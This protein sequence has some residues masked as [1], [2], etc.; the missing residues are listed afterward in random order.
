MHA[1]RWYALIL[2]LVD[3]SGTS[4]G[5][6][7]SCVFNDISVALSVMPVSVHLNQMHTLLGKHSCCTQEWHDH[8]VVVSEPSCHVIHL[9]LQ[10]FL[11]PLMVFSGFFVN[12]YRAQH[13]PYV[14][15]FIPGAQPTGH[16]SCMSAL[17]CQP[18][19]VV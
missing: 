8:L 18:W 6:F 17:Q 4:I 2:V 12:R 14:C 5:I 10:M 11:L 15:A 13:T 16:G 19:L 7:V 3:C 1:A 9:P